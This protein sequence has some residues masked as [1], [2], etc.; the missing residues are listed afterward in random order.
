M[1][2]SLHIHR[3]RIMNSIEFCSYHEA[4]R[5]IGKMWRASK[6]ERA[7]PA[8][9]LNQF[10]SGQLNSSNFPYVPSLSIQRRK[11][12]ALIHRP[13][14]QCSLEEAGLSHHQPRKSLWPKQNLNSSK[15]CTTSMS[16]FTISAAYI[17]TDTDL[18]QTCSILHKEMYSQRIPGSRSQQRR[19]RMHRPMRQQIHGRQCQDQ[20][21]NAGRRCRKT[22]WRNGRNGWHGKIRRS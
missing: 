1:R 17:Q 13:I 14:C 6:L 10:D 22:R 5:D 18:S 2:L 3:K 21:E 19:K 4:A 11:S 9:Y 15:T 12:R 8:E 20:R 7:S 16:F